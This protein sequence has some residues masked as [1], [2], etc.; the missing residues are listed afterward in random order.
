MMKMKA[1][2]F[3][4]CLAVGSVPA[5]AWDG[6]DAETG[7][8]VE[9]EKGNLV[10]PGETIEYYDHDVGAYKEGEVQ[11]IDGSG[12]SVDVEVQDPET[13]ETRTLEM[14]NN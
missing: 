14:D 9:I 2:A 3:F 6:Q 1:A 5:K 12:S 8:S 10:R 13:G 7:A 11:S 4:V